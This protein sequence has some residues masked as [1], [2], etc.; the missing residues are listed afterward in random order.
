MFSIPQWIKLE[1]RCFHREM[2]PSGVGQALVPFS[3]VRWFDNRN[4][5][6]SN[7]FANK[8]RVHLACLGNELR[9][10]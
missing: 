9:I 7:Y 6:D 2:S 4:V 5:D 10:N 8:E 1:K 3:L